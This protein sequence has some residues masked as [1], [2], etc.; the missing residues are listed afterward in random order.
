MEKWNVPPHKKE[1]VIKWEA[2]LSALFSGAIPDS[3][4]WTS[5]EAI[6]RVFQAMQGRD[7]HIF[8]PGSGSEEI[9][10]SRATADGLLEWSGEDDSLDRYAYVVKPVRLVF[11]N[12][13]DHTHEAN[14]I[15][16]VGAMPA[17]C[18]TGY[19]SEVGVEECVELSKGMYAARTAWDENEYNGK[20]LP[21]SARLVC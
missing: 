6:A 14:F 4:E 3:A 7:A 19:A 12:P 17:V 2:K 9:Q 8:L 18:P 15:L 5:P 20:D 16:E 10:S 13:G 11:W 1:M 21:A